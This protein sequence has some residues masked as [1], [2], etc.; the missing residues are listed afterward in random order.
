M[1][2]HDYIC[3]QCSSGEIERIYEVMIDINDKNDVHCPECKGLL[4]KIIGAPAIKVNG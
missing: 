3:P 1:P 2:V 4:I